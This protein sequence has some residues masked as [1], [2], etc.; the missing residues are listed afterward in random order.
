MGC[1]CGEVS[2]SLFVRLEEGSVGYWFLTWRGLVAFEVGY[3]A[4]SLPLL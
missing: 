4:G 2:E 1:Q 3:F